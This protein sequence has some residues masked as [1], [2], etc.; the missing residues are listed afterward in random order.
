MRMA[1]KAFPLGGRWRGTRRM[2]EKY[3]K[4]APSSVTCGDSFPQRGKP[5]LPLRPAP[6][7]DK[8][9]LLSIFLL[10]QNAINNNTNYPH[11]ST[12]NIK[13]RD[14]WTDS[15]YSIIEINQNTDY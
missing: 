9:E 14:K 11:N 1:G 5:K 2:R 15:F 8:L 6:Q 3:P 7:P 12:C 10:I 4:V 13:Y